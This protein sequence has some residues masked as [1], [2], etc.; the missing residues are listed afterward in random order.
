[1]K[2]NLLRDIFIIPLSEVMSDLKILYYIHIVDD[3]EI[4]K[5]D[6]GV[7]NNFDPSTIFQEIPDKSNLDIL[8]DYLK[9]EKYQIKDKIYCVVQHDITKTV[10]TNIVVAN[11]FNGDYSS[12]S[13][14]GC[15]SGYDT[16]FFDNVN[17]NSYG[18][19]FKELFKTSCVNLGIQRLR[20]Y[21]KN[22]KAENDGFVDFYVSVLLNTNKEIDTKQKSVK[23][24]DNK[25]VIL[26]K[27]L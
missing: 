19:I 10:I 21:T 6:G 4:L 9:Q 20:A 17:K 18:T 13:L 5:R 11:K 15:I 2:L 7:V 8:S 25:E 12:I 23:K 27:T 1:M 22:F 24:I 14:S 16:V 3:L 26:K